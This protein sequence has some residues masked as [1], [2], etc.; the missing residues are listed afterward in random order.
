VD[1]HDLGTKK[2]SAFYNNTTISGSSNGSEEVDHLVDMIFS[3][4]EAARF[5]C[6]KLYVWF[7][8]YQ[9]DETTEANVITPLAEI[10]K[11]N[12]Y[13]IKPVL[14]A[15]FK[16]EHF[17]D[18]QNQACYIK[19]PFD[20]I[21]GVMRDFN[22]SFPAYTDH[23]NG[24]P[25]FY[26]MYKTAA[27]MQQDLFQP[28]DVSGWPAYHQDPMHYELWVNSNSLPRRADFTD[29][30]VR[31]SVIDVRAVVANTSDPANADT[32]VADIT[33]L[34]L[35]YPLSAA[36]RD[37]VKNKFLLNNTGDNTVWTIAWNSNNNAVINP[38]LNEMFKFL[39]NL[40]E[41]QLC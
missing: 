26:N 17:F 30:L 10:L 28:P 36:S 12:N 23:V 38:A 41:F 16:S 4:I 7:V 2:F 34:L 19:S 18:I 31:D 22:V 33:A 5:I 21:V 9:I 13:E 14:E 11:N 40:P 27:R 1:S 39:M 24:Y 20:I 32:L 37:Y 6:R 15:L 3:N 25:L 29:S 8:Y 35:R